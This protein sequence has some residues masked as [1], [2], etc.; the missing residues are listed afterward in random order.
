MKW[1]PA[2]WF[3]SSGKVEG[4]ASLHF[5]DRTNARYFLSGSL[6]GDVIEMELALGPNEYGLPFRNRGK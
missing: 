4:T 5:R 6:N 3:N 1:G 2:R